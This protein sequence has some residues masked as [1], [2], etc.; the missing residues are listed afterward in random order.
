MSQQQF[1]VVVIGGGPGGYI[2]AIRA[3]T[4]DPSGIVVPRIELHSFIAGTHPA[5]GFGGILRPH[6]YAQ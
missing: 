4:V 1:D 5:K 3:G 2:A 6:R